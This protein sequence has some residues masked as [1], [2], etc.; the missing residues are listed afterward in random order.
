MDLDLPLSYAG[1]SIGNIIHIPLINDERVFG[2]DYSKIQ[3]LNNQPIYPLWI[4]TSVDLKM[5]KVVIKAYQLHYL[6]DDGL[7]G[8]VFPE[9]VGEN[10]AFA[11][12]LQFNSQFPEIHNWNYLPPYHQDPDY[13]Y[14]Q[15]VEIPYGDVNGD[16]AINVQDMLQVMNHILGNSELTSN[17][18][19][20][21]VGY[22]FNNK[23]IIAYSDEMEPTVTHLMDLCFI[24]TGVW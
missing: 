18:K 5:E 4:I 6:N 12:L 14:V 11:N 15:D 3:H 21:I 1:L 23:E 24:I 19:R 17:E 22:D 10:I 16:Q 20:R 8:F 2:L 7:H 13:V 9:G